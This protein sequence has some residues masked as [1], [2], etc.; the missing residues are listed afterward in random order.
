MNISALFQFSSSM[1]SI[2]NELAAIS[3]QSVYLKDYRELIYM[4]SSY[5]GT[6]SVIKQED[7]TIEL[8]GVYFS[9]PGQ[10]GYALENINLK[11]QSK[12]KISIVGMNGAGKTTFVKLLMG[13]YHPTKGSIY[14]NGINIEKLDSQQY[15]QLF[16]AVF[17]DYQLYSFTL[18]E[19]ILFS[20]QPSEEECFR[21]E[22]CLGKIGLD[23][24]IK[25]YSKGVHSYI[26]Q[27]YS[28]EGFELSGGESQKLAISR[29]LYRNA[30]I[31]VL[32][33]P[34]SALSPQ[35]EYDIYQHFNQLVDDKTVFYI[36][37]RLS[38]CTICDRI[39]VFD[40]GHIVEDGSHLQLLK[41]EGLYAQMFLKQSSFYS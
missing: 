7:Y 39:L 23:T 28:S 14:F 41:Q 18:L 22:R 37:H 11:I 30:P 13:L 4:K 34:T 27:Q 8:I 3:E 2:I 16:S 21:A 31:I 24:K 25:K 10:E 19:N 36:S 12:K 29:A 26:T 32:D 1:S 40:Q 6:Q 15:L 20:E 17:Q 35:N 9:Y 38:S 33:E 5:V